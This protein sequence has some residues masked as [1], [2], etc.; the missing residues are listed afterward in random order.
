MWR[1][2]HKRAVIGMAWGLIPFW[3]V[4]C[5]LAMWRWRESACRL[6]AKLNVAWPLKFVIGCIFLAMLEEVVTTAMTNCAPLFGVKIG[7]AY[8]T[9]SS[10]Y[11]DVILRHSVVVFVPMFIGWA[12]LLKFWRFSP[13]EVFVLWG[14]T[15]TFLEFTYS[16]CQ[17]IPN[18]PFWILVYGPMVW[19]PA[20]FVDASR[21]ARAPKWWSYPIGVII[22]PLFLPLNVLIA[23]WLWLLGKHPN[24]HFAAIVEDNIVD[25]GTSSPIQRC[26]PRSRSPQPMRLRMR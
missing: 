8:I 10:N 16:G 13:F 17:G 4:G 25:G 19:L 14:L 15:G 2:P 3:I 24:I 6:V 1:Q 26:N 5:G 11:F 7:E 18:F 23:P 9:A 21:A 22:P 12:V 20:H